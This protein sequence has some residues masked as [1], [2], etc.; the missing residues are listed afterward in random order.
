MQTNVTKVI[1]LE[2]ITLSVE[3]TKYDAGI[4]IYP[5]PNNGLFQIRTAMPVQ[6]NSLMAITGIAGRIVYT[7][8]D[9]F[10][11][12]QTIDISDNPSGIYFLITKKWIKKIVKQ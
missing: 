2:K 6:E 12:F 4:D 8:Q 10:T 3:Q 7:N 11:H 1:D 5:S 9:I